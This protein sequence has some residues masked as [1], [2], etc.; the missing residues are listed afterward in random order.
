MSFDMS[1]FGDSRWV[2][3]HPNNVCTHGSTEPILTVLDVR[4]FPL[5]D[6]FL[7]GTN[8][9]CGTLVV[10]NEARAQAASAALEPAYATRVYHF[11]RRGGEDLW[12][13]GYQRRALDGRTLSSFLTDLTLKDGTVV[14]R[15]GRWVS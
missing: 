9:S 4:G 12:A 7:I 6:M 15:D 2:T 3:T 14:I 1:R 13:T 11:G 10:P 8:D 5:R